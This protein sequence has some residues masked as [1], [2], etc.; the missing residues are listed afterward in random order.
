[1]FTT[2]QLTSHQEYLA[3]QKRQSQDDFNARY[4]AAKTDFGPPC[5]ALQP[6]LVLTVKQDGGTD[7]VQGFYRPG[8]L[9]QC[10]ARAK[11]FLQHAFVSGSLRATARIE[12]YDPT[13]TTPCR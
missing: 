3:N 13:P 1:V 7:D 10:M 12:L 2:P 6:M 11:S 9:D 8:Q 4:A 5:T